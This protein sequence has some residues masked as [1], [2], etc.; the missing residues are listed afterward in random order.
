[1]GNLAVST[2]GRATGA[3]ASAADAGAWA[4]PEIGAP[5]LAQAVSSAS[6]NKETGRFIDFITM[7]SGAGMR[8]EYHAA[9]LFLH[10][11]GY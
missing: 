8:V 3:D 10:F 11:M 1:L 2:G 5:L 4:E 9:G 7:E 6:N